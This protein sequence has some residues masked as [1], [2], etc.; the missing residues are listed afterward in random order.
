MHS[1]SRIVNASYHHRNEISNIFWCDHIYTMFTTCAIYI[2]TSTHKKR[3]AQFHTDQS[4]PGKAKIDYG[5]NNG[6]RFGQRLL[7]SDNL[8]MLVKVKRHSEILTNWTSNGLC[9]TDSHLFH[10]LCQPSKEDIIFIWALRSVDANMP[11]YL[12]VCNQAVL[13]YICGHCGHTVPND[14]RVKEKYSF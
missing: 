12:S 7:F 9:C 5:Q 10:S 8:S 4:M 6:N 2:V 13:L 14:R 1:H 11:L 3:C